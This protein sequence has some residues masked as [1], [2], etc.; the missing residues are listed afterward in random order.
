MTHIPNLLQS[1]TNTESVQNHKKKFECAVCQKAYVYELAR[2]KHEVAV[3]SHNRA[4]ESIIETEHDLQDPLLTVDHVLAYQKASLTF[5]LLLRNINDSIREGDGERLLECYR[6]AILYFKGFGHTKYAFT[7]LK[8]FFHIKF[9]PE[10][11]FRII[12]GRFINNKGII[13]RNISRDLHLEHLNNFLKELLRSLRSNLNEKNADRIAKCVRNINIII[14]N[15]EDSLDISCK[16]HSRKVND[17]YE[18]VKKLSLE[19]MKS[20]VFNE[21]AGRQY[22]S[23]P[24]FNEDIL[25]KLNIKK[26]FKWI[27]GKK[28]DF[29]ELYLDC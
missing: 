14:S 1:K 5:G 8:M 10:D 3:H 15:L 11:A 7:L 29:E 23:F 22:D 13:G 16:P 28:K 21:N 20:D 27:C 4:T 17:S 2:N 19:Y 18:D 9:R 12:W 26:L 6:F 25:S 24:R